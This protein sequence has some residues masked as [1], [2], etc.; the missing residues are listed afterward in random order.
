MSRRCTTSA[1]TAPA[2]HATLDG[3]AGIDWGISGVPETFVIDGHGI[4]RARISGA[5]TEGDK[6]MDR[7][8]PAIAAAKP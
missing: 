2:I 8:L 4:V 7:L 5:L 6:Y 3:S 1:P